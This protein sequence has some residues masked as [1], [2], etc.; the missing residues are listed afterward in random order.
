MRCDPA[1]VMALNFK[2]GEPGA[3]PPAALLGSADVSGGRDEQAGGAGGRVAV[4]ERPLHV[5]EARERCCG[6]AV[7]GGGGKIRGGDGDGD[8]VPGAG[9]K[10]RRSVPMEWGRRKDGASGGEGVVFHD[11]DM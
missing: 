3:P 7:G 11:G 4:R 9:G 1:Q 6:A 10:G 2:L 8:K 5:C